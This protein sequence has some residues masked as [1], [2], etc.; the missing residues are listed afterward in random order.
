[1]THIYFIFPYL[2]VNISLSE[3]SVMDRLHDHIFCWFRFNLLQ[4]LK[5]VFEKWRKYEFDFSAFRNGIRI[6]SCW[7][8]PS[9][10]TPMKRRSTS[11]VK[12]RTTMEQAQRHNLRWFSAFVVNSIYIQELAIFTTV[13]YASTIICR[14]PIKSHYLRHLNHLFY[15]LVNDREEKTVELS[16]LS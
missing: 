6:S 4:Y 12:K 11:S 3:C 9:C 7:P 1:M 15:W 8:H 10:T 16:S 14:K 2:F 5:F 13:F